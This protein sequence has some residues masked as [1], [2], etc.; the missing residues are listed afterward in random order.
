MKPNKTGK[1]FLPNIEILAQTGLLKDLLGNMS[2]LKT[3]IK[4]QLRVKDESEFVNRYTWYNL[5]MD[6]DSEMLERILYYKGQVAFFLEPK[7]KKFYFAIPV[8]DGGIDIYGRWN[9][10]HCIPFYAGEEDDKKNSDKKKGDKLWSYLADLKLNVKYGVILFP[11]GEDVFESA[12]ILRDY[13]NQLPQSI[14]PR[15]DLSDKLLEAMAEC[16]PFM[17]T[18]LILGTGVKGVRVG[19]ADQADSVR[20]GSEKL[21]EAALAGEGYIP[22]EAM[23]EFQELSDNSAGKAEEYMAA[24]QAL[25][26]LRKET[27]GIPSNGVFQKKAHMLGAEQALN[28]ANVD[29]VLQD[30]LAQRQNFCAIINSIW[31]LGVSCEINES[32]SMVDTNGDGVVYDRNEGE[33]SGTNPESNEGGSND[34]AE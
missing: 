31:G 1:P 27:M 25:D 3:D 20:E 18:R 17:R 22:I 9:R 24:Y 23:A 13:T 30:G 33:K 8:L 2:L 26:N 7:T 28:G 12:V 10:I 32:I 21:V 14:T 16:I 5:P 4:R 6:V 29:L 11:T 19:D 34:G 15:K